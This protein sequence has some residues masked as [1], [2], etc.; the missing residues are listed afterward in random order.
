MALR[1]DCRVATSSV[2]D[3]R[4][5]QVGLHKL[6]K[7]CHGGTQG[8]TF[9]AGFAWPSSNLTKSGDYPVATAGIGRN[10]GPSWNNP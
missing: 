10:H 2:G 4:P 7:Y 5:W 3:A 6:F 8:R 1:T 9:F